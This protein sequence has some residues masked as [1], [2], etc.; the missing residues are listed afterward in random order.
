MMSNQSRPAFP[1]KVVPERVTEEKTFVQ[2]AAAEEVPPSPRKNWRAIVLA[3]MADLV[4]KPA[5]TAEVQAT[6]EPQPTEL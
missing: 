3:G 6:S 4:E 1:A 5:S 2:R